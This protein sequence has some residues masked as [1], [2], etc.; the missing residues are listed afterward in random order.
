MLKNIKDKCFCRKFLKKGEEY[1]SAN[2]VDIVRYEISELIQYSEENYV[3]KELE[4]KGNYKTLLISF[5]E[6][7]SVPE[8]V[9]DSWLIFHGI[10]GKGVLTIAEKETK[11]KTGTIVSIPPGVSRRLKCDDNKLTVLAVQVN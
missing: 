3:K 4:V 5:L 6:G 1:E 2:M 9:M 10:E 7:Q 11:I 8:C